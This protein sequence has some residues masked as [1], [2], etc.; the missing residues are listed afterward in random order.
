MPYIPRDRRQGIADAKLRVATVLT[1]AGESMSGTESIR[2]L[3][4]ACKRVFFARMPGESN[5]EYFDRVCR[6][7]QMPQ[8][9]YCGAVATPRIVDVMHGP[10]YT[11]EPHLRQAEIDAQPTP[12]SMPW[13]GKGAFWRQH[14]NTEPF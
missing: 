11:P 13:D 8:Q 3:L 10:A 12:C 9:T 2:T 14:G 1:S 6:D 5:L 4:S 7:A